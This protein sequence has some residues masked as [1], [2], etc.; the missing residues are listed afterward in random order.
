M[1]SFNIF[2]FVSVRAYWCAF[3]V[4]TLWRSAFPTKSALSIYR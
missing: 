1:L 3:N 2:L 4:F